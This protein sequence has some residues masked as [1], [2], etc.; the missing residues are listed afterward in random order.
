MLCSVI[1]ITRSKEIGPFSV[2][3]VLEKSSYFQIFELLN[4][5]GYIEIFIFPEL[6]V[7]IGVI[8]FLC[9]S[10]RTAKSVFHKIYE[11]SFVRR[12]LRSSK[13][14]ETFHRREGNRF[15]RG[16]NGPGNKFDGSRL[17]SRVEVI[18]TV[19]VSRLP[20]FRRAGNPGTYEKYLLRA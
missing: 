5:D 10:D 11:R 18:K 13:L 8:S 6:H 1:I 15:T 16:G 9:S 2:S 12:V 7:L 20:A 3:A 4:R 14:N 17:I 19:A